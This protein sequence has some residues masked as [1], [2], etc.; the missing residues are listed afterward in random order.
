[1][2]NEEAHPDGAP[3]DNLWELTTRRL[4][5]PRDH[6]R[7]AAARRLSRPDGR[8][9]SAVR[10][11]GRGLRGAIRR[12]RSSSTPDVDNAG[13]QFITDLFENDVVLVSSTDD[14]NAA[15]GA[16]G[17]ANPPIGFTTYSDRRDNEDEGWALQ[18]ANDVEPSNGIIFPAL[19]ALSAN[20]QQP[21][22]CAARHRLPDGR[23]QRNRRRGL[24]ALLCRRAT[25]P[26]AAT[27]SRHPDAVPLE[28]FIAWRIDPA[29]T[30][31]DPR[32]RSPT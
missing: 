6:G 24:C 20:T 1:M 11:D 9:R 29:A 17:Q 26:P 16:I 21:G 4:D 3:V 15:I 5:G 18:V 10:R 32:R 30:A 25:M 31:D 27:S 12:A 7:S 19:L 2:Y 23:R 28:E 14:V 8:N 22:R 13:Q